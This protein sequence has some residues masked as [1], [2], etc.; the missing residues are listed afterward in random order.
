MKYGTY[1]ASGYKFGLVNNPSDNYQGIKFAIKDSLSRGEESKIPQEPKNVETTVRTNIR[2]IVPFE[3]VDGLSLEELKN[4]PSL[5]YE[6]RYLVFVMYDSLPLG[7]CLLDNYKIVFGEPE[8]E[9][10]ARFFYAIDTEQNKDRTI[11][12][13]LEAHLIKTLSKLNVQNRRRAL[14]FLE[15]YVNTSKEG[16][17]NMIDNY[18]DARAKKE[19]T[20]RDYSWR[21]VK[22]PDRLINK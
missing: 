11:D 4:Y 16:T 8:E 20:V 18:L 2:T 1:V 21:Y 17:N 14:C 5:L 13:V 19:S 12:E 10:T 22:L 7:E 9:C 15:K 3:S 6:G